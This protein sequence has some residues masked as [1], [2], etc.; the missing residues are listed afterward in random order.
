MGDGCGTL[1]DKPRRVGAEEPLLAVA[2]LQITPTSA[3]SR[4]IA[5]VRI[6]QLAPAIVVAL[7][8]GESLTFAFF[9]YLNRDEGW[10]LVSGKLAYH[11]QLPYR[12]FPYFQTPLLPYLFGAVNALPAHSFIKVRCGRLASQPQSSARR[13]SETRARKHAS[14]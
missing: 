2:D 13:R 11:G 5:R 9:G 7:F 12:D 6:E 3:I 8:A 14:R 4:I 1:E 10:Y